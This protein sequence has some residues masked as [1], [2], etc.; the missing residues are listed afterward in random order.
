MPI[1][2]NYESSKWSKEI[3]KSA[4]KS[5]QSS[6]VGSFPWLIASLGPLSLDLI[7][8]PRFRKLVCRVCTRF[9]SSRAWK[10]R[11]GIRDWYA[12][13]CGGEDAY[14]VAQICARCRG[15]GELALKKR[16]GDGGWKRRS[17]SS[18]ARARNREIWKRKSP[19]FG[20]S[21]RIDIPRRS[22]T[23]CARRAL[24]SLHEI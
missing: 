11:R 3:R 18:N 12:R 23:H 1:D 5:G 6:E 10:R 13:V 17:I 15:I 19:E 8:Q 7:K 4:K 2:V 20:I 16:A 22:G 24:S 9:K 14:S 21:R